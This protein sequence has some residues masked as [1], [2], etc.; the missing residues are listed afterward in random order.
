MLERIE[1]GRQA[2]L[3]KARRD[4]SRLPGAAN[5]KRLGHG[6]EIG[7][8]ACGHRGGD[9]HCGRNTGSIEAAQFGAR[10]GCGDRPEH[11]RRVPALAMQRHRFPFQKFGPD[12]VACDIG[13]QHLGAARSARLALRED[14]RHQHG[15]RMAVERNVVVV[16]NVRSNAIDQRRGFDRAPAARWNERSECAAAS[17][18]QFAI[19]ERDRG[20]TRA[21][22]Q[23]AEAIGNAAPRDTAAF[24]GNLAQAEIGD[25]AA[26]IDG[27]SGHERLR[28]TNISA[29][30][31]FRDSERHS[32]SAAHRKQPI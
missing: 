11:R 3:R 25:E 13:R 4:Q 1:R 19:D 10:R 20:V 5:L 6:A 17:V 27:E 8:Q 9:R 31:W 15:A 24:G 7:D 30:L 22:D 21:S 16:Q 23:N 32:R 28:W 2:R 29:S 14:R 26:K 18:T 12:L